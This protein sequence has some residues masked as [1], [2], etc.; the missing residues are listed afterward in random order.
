MH[1][2]LALC[3]AQTRSE[4]L[5]LNSGA[6]CLLV[7]VFLLDL[8]RSIISSPAFRICMA[9][10]IYLRDLTVPKSSAAQVTFKWCWKVHKTLF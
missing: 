2:I 7:P 5:L 8:S 3:S 9:H 10:L 1:T 4:I 6:Q